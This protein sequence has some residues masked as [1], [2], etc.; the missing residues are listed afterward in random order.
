MKTSEKDEMLK[1]PI[2][3][4]LSVLSPTNAAGLISD[5]LFTK[6]LGCIRG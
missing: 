2:A 3:A 4:A 5:A 1:I 6:V